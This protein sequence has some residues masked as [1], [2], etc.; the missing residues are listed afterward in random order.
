MTGGEGTTDEALMASYVAGDQRAF[1]ELFA[2]YAPRLTRMFGRDLRPDDA[3]DLMQQTFLQ[4]HRARNDFR[5][6]A[7]LRPWLY[8]IARNLLRQH[9]RRRGR[10]PEASLD[11]QGAAEPIAPGVTPEQQAEAR[12][13]RQVLGRLPATQAEV[14]SLHWFEG[15][16]FREVAQVVGASESAVKVR[17]HRGYAKLRELIEGPGVTAPGAGAYMPAAPR[18]RA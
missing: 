13:V 17:A 3:H 10:R 2:R 8:T 16:S 15:L 6:D 14:I 4:L 18:N 1:A 9:F 7:K 11:A 12:Q 5:Q